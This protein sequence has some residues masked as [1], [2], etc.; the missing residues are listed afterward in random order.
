MEIHIISNEQLTIENINNEI[1]NCFEL[2]KK[3]GFEIVEK[4]NNFKIF[5]FMKGRLIK[6]FL[7]MDSIDYFTL[8]IF[9]NDDLNYLEIYTTPLHRK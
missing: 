9:Y 1:S 4:E 8:E 6:Y 5:N 3:N 2:C 7:V